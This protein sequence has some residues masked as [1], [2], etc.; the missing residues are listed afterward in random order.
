MAQKKA[1]LS[2]RGSQAATFQNH[3]TAESQNSLINQNYIISNPAVNTSQENSKSPQ[4]VS[5][6][7]ATMDAK[8]TQEDPQKLSALTFEK[9]GSL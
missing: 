4:H 2:K 8:Y 9:R 7:E 6:A 3:L 1:S 5:G